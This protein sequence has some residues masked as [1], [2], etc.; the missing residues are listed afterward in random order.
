MCTLEAKALWIDNPWLYTDVEKYIWISNSSDKHKAAQN[1]F[2]YFLK[3]KIYIKGFVTDSTSMVG[4]KMFHKPIFDSDVLKKDNTVVFCDLDLDVSDVYSSGADIQYVKII[5]PALCKADGTVVI[6]GSGVTG[7]Q[8]FQILTENGVK[9]KYF[10]DSDKKKIGLLKCGLPIYSSKK[11]EGENPDPVIVEA[12][13]KWKELDD[14]I[15]GRY[16][17]R[18]YYQ[19]QPRMKFDL[20]VSCDIDGVERTI[21]SL[22]SDMFS[23]IEDK[24]IYI[25]GIGH[26]ER[27]MAGYLELMDFDVRGF[28]TDSAEEEGK[29]GKY[30]VKYIEKV[31]YESDFIIWIYDE[32]KAEKLRQLGLKYFKDY[33]CHMYITDITIRKKNV[34]DINLGYN[35]LLQSEYPGFVVYG[36]ERKEDYKIVI[37]GNSTTDGT[38]YSF[39]SW[40]QLL[41]EKIEE[42]ITV[43]NGGTYAYNSG[44][45]VIKLMRDAL[46]LNP[47]M[48]IVYDGFCDMYCMDEYPYSAGYLRKIFKCVSKGIE[49]PGGVYPEEI[50]DIVCSGIA[51]RRKRFDNWLSNIRT[52]FAVARERNIC[53]FSFCQPTLSSKR[54]KTV[55]EKNM[56]LSARSDQIDFQVNQSFRQYIER[57]P[58]V[59]AYI[60]DLSDI[61]DNKPDIYMDIC[62][63]CEEGNRIISNKIMEAILPAIKGENKYSGLLWREN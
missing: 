24:K 50:T 62:H 7:E 23:Y 48:I 52:M 2:S 20:Y 35:F 47:N 44:Q 55:R 59:P 32:S 11:L 56:L 8:V 36:N 6:W 3:K 1:L 60:Q 19:Y 57:A 22:D 58:C 49:A 41:Y 33:I 30:S 25:Y 40:P 13:E 39:K 46:L 45:E 4:L 42:N 38:L 26:I 28:L 37:L 18:F 61:F 51:S 27:A 31:L 16:E 14:I 43:Y 12:M 34:L 10:V 5:N 21:F 54:G 53:F 29:E 15:L 63:V 9:V 17:R